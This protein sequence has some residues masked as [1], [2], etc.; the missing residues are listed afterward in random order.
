MYLCMYTRKGSQP[1]SYLESMQRV[2]WRLQVDLALHSIKCLCIQVQNLSAMNRMCLHSFTFCRISKRCRI[3]PYTRRE[4]ARQTRAHTHT[5]NVCVHVYKCTC[6]DLWMY[7][8]AHT[9]LHFFSPLRSHFRPPPLP[10][11]DVLYVTTRLYCL[12]LL[13]VSTSS[14]CL[15]FSLSLALSVLPWP[16]RWDLTAGVSRLMLMARL[17]TTPMLLATCLSGFS[18]ARPTTTGRTTTVCFYVSRKSSD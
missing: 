1:A 11:P 16:R 12:F 17:I 10:D 18:L 4:R 15:P 6:M 3:A 13:S 7:V 5:N 2:P 8:H 9:Y 14:L